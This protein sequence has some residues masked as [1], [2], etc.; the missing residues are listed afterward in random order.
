MYL[1]NDRGEITHTQS[2]RIVQSRNGLAFGE[3]RAIDDARIREITAA[4]RE[5]KQ[6]NRDIWDFMPRLDAHLRR[7]KSRSS[8]GTS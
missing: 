3:K 6:I 2:T 4:I 5:M 8:D 1:V 7:Q